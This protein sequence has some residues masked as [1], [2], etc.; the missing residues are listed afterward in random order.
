M[1]GLSRRNF[2]PSHVHVIG[3]GL[4]GLSCALTLKER[5]VPVT[6]YDAVPQAGGRC[7]SFTDATLGRT[8]D[9]G[10]HL[11]LRG[12]RAAWRYIAR[13]RSFT[14]FYSLC[15]NYVFHNAA[16]QRQWV[17]EPPMVPGIWQVGRLLL[18]RPN[19]TVT[20]CFG[21]T[22]FYREFIEPL[23]LAALNTHPRAASAK[24]LRSVL[25]RV[26]L[27]TQADFLQLRTDFNRALITPALARLENVYLTQRLRE[28]EASNERVTGLQ[29]TEFHRTIGEDERVVLALP[30]EVAASLL[31][32]IKLPELAHH[33]I[34]NGHFLCDTDI[35]IPHML[36]VVNSPLHWVF[37]KDGLISTTTSHA[38]STELWG[39]ENIAEIL[40]SELGKCYPSLKNTPLPPHRI[41]TEKRATIATTPQN[42]ARRPQAETP[43]S[44]LFLAGDWLAS[45]LPACLESAIRSGKQA[46]RLCLRPPAQ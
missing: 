4:A 29:F 16:E 36:G 13:L 30:P 20:Q 28:V 31:P 43:Y 42:L 40:W 3:A 26:M 18:A 2:K 15:P 12:N 22:A 27:P 11:I 35:L 34:I 14:E 8:I 33:A 32:Q 21:N 19:Q 44:N 17:V 1:L 23:C 7:R 9:N 5:G 38:E 46:A 37:L 39:K 45:P 10:N 24:M 6:L 41:I 25:W